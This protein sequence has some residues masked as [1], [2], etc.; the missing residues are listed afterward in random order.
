MPS[1]PVNEMWQEIRRLKARVCE[2]EEQLQGCDPCAK[3]SFIDVW[4]DYDDT[5][6]V[7][8]DGVAILHGQ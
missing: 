7:D 2:L 5:P 6:V 1:P 4:I 8:Y 3:D